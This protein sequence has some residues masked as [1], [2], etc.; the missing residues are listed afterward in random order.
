MGVKS[1]KEI[2]AAIKAANTQ[3]DNETIE[4]F[5]TRRWN[6]L[7]RVY[8]KELPPKLKKEAD[9]VSIDGA[10]RI[11]IESYP[12]GSLDDLLR[13]PDHFTELIKRA[14]LE[15]RYLI[16]S[17]DTT[18]PE[19][20]GNIK[21]DEA[22]AEMWQPVSLIAIDFL[23][24]W[25]R[26]TGQTLPKVVKLPSLAGKRVEKLDFPVDKV[27]SK[28]WDILGE[29]T[30]GQ[31]RMISAES[32]KDKRKGKQINILYAIDFENIDKAV[33]ITKRLTPYDELVYIAISALF[34]VGNDYITT[35]QIYNAMGF[36]GRPSKYDIDKINKAITKMSGA[37][38]HIDNL[39]EIQAKYKYPVVKYDGSLLPMERASIIINGQLAEAAIHIFREPPL[40]SF[41]RGR[42]QI[43]TIER[44]LLASPI[45]K[46]DQNIR[47]QTY[48]IE[49]IS[50][51]KNDSKSSN[52]ILFETLY[53]ETGINTAKQKQRAPEK[54]KQLLDHYKECDFI[55][56]YKPD[57][58]E[59]IK[60]ADGVAIHY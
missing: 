43:T 17:I 39:E 23:E 29:D 52:K 4:D 14:F 45:S 8:Y 5:S 46:T 57:T 1:L 35:A 10:R 36:E 34:S 59:E 13:Q 60:A 51:I 19:K 21:V 42:K 40:I 56:G 50:R 30:K 20:T 25:E 3:R 12:V 49:R 27:N 54:I 47:L 32:L 15:A 24:A 26:V 31:I 38:I 58:L 37:R 9:K 28:I 7:P 44:K 48:L 16:E 41:A 55:K 18:P 2:D 53:S 11:V 6:E 33:S 22:T